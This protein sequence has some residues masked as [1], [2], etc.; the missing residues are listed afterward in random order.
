MKFKIAVVQFEINQYQPEKN[1]K[2]AKDFVKKAA[3]SK[4]QIIVF[5][6]D[7]LS[8]GVNDDEII[9]FADSKGKYRKIF[10]NLAKKY[11][12]DIVAGSII[13][14]NRI[15]N[16]NVCYYIDSTGKIKGKYKKINLW[17]TERKMIVSGNEVCVFN[18][19]YGKV[20][21][22]ICWD[23]IF[24]EIFR[25]MVKKGANIIF[26]PSLWYRGKAFKHCKNYNPKTQINRVNS[27]CKIRANRN[28]IIFVYI[29]AVGKLRT[30]IGNNFDEAIGQSQ[31]TIP[32]RIVLQK[33]NNK[34]E[35]FIQ[36]VDTAILKDA[37]RAYKIRDDLR[38]R[39]L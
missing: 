25:R 22:I 36:E 1:L 5:P 32:G 8:G 24:P 20:G 6:E 27:L 10:Q 18:T 34:E 4:A 13:E 38:N 31:I 16:F 28:N 11:K 17:L 26:C 19:K 30:S 7:F 35:M 37:E 12:I 23:L 15:G 3:F 33:L 2:K 29:N 39:I 9:Q 14:K 21:L